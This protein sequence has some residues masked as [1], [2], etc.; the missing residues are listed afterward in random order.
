MFRF[1]NPEYLYL[2]FLV[3]FM[4]LLYLVVKKRYYKRLSIFGNIDTLHKLMPE[5]LWRKTTYKFIII[6]ISFIFFIIAL[7][8]PQ[9]GAKL[10]EVKQE[11]IEL[12]FV[13]D[14]SN[15]MLADDYKPSR[16]ERTKNAINTLLDKFTNDRVGL[17]VFAGKAFVQ[18]PITSDYIAAKRFV[19][20]ISPGMITAQG[21]SI[22]NALD[23]SY[24]S[25]SS[26]S[27]GS[28][29]VILISDGE[30]HDES[31]LKIAKKM[32]DDGI[33]IST[34]GIGTPSGV[35]LNIGGN[36]VTDENGNIVV[37]KL[38]EEVLKQ[39]AL[40]TGG[41]YVKASNTSIGLNELVSQLRSIDDRE[42][43]STKFESY[44][45]LFQYFL[46]PGLLLILLEFMMLERRNRIINRMKLFN[47]E[48][49]EKNK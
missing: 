37:T 47:I 31:P 3:L 26:E 4:F 43:S 39:I 29:A 34:I 2:L 35:A 30:N 17:V 10:R 19:E 18:L 25:F 42:F 8:R 20:Y 49:D 24:R 6:S 16:L 41:T 1:A 15:S 13:V 38:N 5:V 36:P 48:K 14:V 27:K 32:A 46:I 33:I 44:N 23:V 11:G 21:T 22:E 28:R 45:E 7:A 40:T 12:M 9:M